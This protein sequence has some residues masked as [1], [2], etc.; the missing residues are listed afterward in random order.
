MD[1]EIQTK[2]IGWQ[3]STIPLAMEMSTRKAH[4]VVRT[5]KDLE[6]PKVA[7]KPAEVDRPI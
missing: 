1:E 2:S 3:Q 5:G 6:T 7:D 4:E